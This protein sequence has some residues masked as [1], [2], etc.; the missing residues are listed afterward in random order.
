L[1]L[2]S[3]AGGA[4]RGLQRA[5]FFVVGVDHRPQPRYAGNLFVRGDALNPP[6]DLSLFDLIHASP[7]CQDHS[8][9][10]QLPWLRDKTY[11]NLIPQARELLLRSGR[12]FVIENVP[13]APLRRDLVL[14]GTMFGLTCYRHRVFEIGGFFCLEPPHAKHRERIGGALHLGATRPKGHT[15][16]A[17][18]A[19]GSWGKGDFV[20]VA[21]HQFKRCDGAAALGIDWMGS[22]AELAQ[23]VPP[24]YSEY[25]GRA[26]LRFLGMP[27]D[28][29]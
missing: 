14:C 19:R 11:P 10:R 5:G 25:I 6:F 15:L 16:N 20:T 28:A 26:A 4:A 3:G 22:R 8:I 9:L 23:A 12:P 1:D 2:F 13:G 27:G 21:G 7:P 24:A 18:S 29:I 17:G